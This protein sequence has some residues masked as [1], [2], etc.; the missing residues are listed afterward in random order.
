MMN[1][2]YPISKWAVAWIGVP[3]VT[4]TE[5]K[6]SRGTR[7]LLKQHRAAIPPL[8]IDNSWQS[9][10]Q[11][12]PQLHVE[13]RKPLFSL[14]DIGYSVFFLCRQQLNTGDL[15]CRTP[16]NGQAKPIDELLA[17][18]RGGAALELV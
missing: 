12:L 15:Q 4:A 3:V 9:E 14:L 10:I 16:V 17:P 5:M 1:T 2:E 7:D 11:L 18:W 13:P 6:S 8:V